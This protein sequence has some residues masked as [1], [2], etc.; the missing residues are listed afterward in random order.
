M[1][2][3]ATTKA[4]LV[5][6]VVAIARNANLAVLKRRKIARDASARNCVDV[7]RN[8]PFV[9]VRVEVEGMGEAIKLIT[10]LDMKGSRHREH[11]MAELLEAKQKAE[12]RG[13]SRKSLG[14]ESDDETLM[15]YCRIEQKRFPIDSTGNSMS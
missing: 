6:F 12:S 13:G 3:H 8:L 11:G 14:C 9:I 10:V 2:N 1:T 5:S 7:K 4:Q 15:S